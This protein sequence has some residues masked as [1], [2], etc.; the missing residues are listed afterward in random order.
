MM[1][2]LLTLFNLPLP[3]LLLGMAGCFLL[4]LVVIILVA[5]IP[6][7]GERFVRFL[8]S[9]EEVFYSGPTTKPSRLVKRPSQRRR[10]GM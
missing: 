6:S 1:K 8:V 10:R 7:A 9:F 4:F 2:L 5:C 3:V